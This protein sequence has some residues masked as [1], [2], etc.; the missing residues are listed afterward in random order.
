MSEKPVKLIPFRRSD[1]ATAKVSNAPIVSMTVKDGKIQFNKAAS[2]ML[3]IAEGDYLEL[4][5]DTDNP[6]K[7]WFRRGSRSDGFLVHERVKTKSDGSHSSNG[8]HCIISKPLVRHI[9]TI[10]GTDKNISVQ[11]GTEM[12]S[13]AFWTLE[14][15]YD[16]TAPK[17]FASRKANAPKR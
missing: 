8:A 4:G 15:S 12:E 16:F 14:S 1:L 3:G 5:A 2:R 13:G 17:T 7:L 9:Q 11:L 10:L 6:K